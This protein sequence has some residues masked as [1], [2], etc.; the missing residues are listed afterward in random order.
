MTIFV[1]DTSVL[2]SA[3]KKA[4]SLYPGK[5][6]VVPLVVITEL[7][8]KRND[9]ELGLTARSALR[10]IKELRQ[11]GD[12]RTGV[13]IANGSVV[14]VEI[15]HIDNTNLPD[16]V[17]RD[18]S[19]DAKILAVAASLKAVLVTQDIP[20]MIKADVV[21]VQSEP[22]PA[23]APSFEGGD[24]PVVVLSDHDI[25]E[26]HEHGSV[27][28]EADFPV[29]TG[30][31]IGTYAGDGAGIGIIDKQWNVRRV[32][33]PKIM[34]IEGRN[35]QQRFA[36]DHLLN[37]NIGIVSLGGK[38]GSGKSL[39]ALAA[40]VSQVSAGKYKKVVVFKPA[41]EVLGGNLGY[42]PGSLEEKFAG[43][44]ASVYD[45]AE[46]FS[47][48]RDFQSLIKNNQ[49]EILPVSH[50]RGRTLNNSFIIFDEAQNAEFSTLLTVLTRVGRSSKIVL[51]HDLAQRD[52][53]H[54]GKHQGVYEVVSRFTG[55][56]LFA[57]VEMVKSERSEIAEMA[58]TILGDYM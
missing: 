14:R 53:L 12:I 17:R 27:K 1:L 39:L 25:T 10:F 34:G 49:L 52:N 44:T 35:I 6:V 13:R 45:A 46:A 47:G 5:E 42:L 22:I 7:E 55:N 30:V 8:K 20:L 33:S 2:L 40:G 28:T 51:A 43:F 32:Q 37:E 19:N 24:I 38:S 9:P 16:S 29:N 26:F 11:Q 3:G 58:A 23:L 18:N 54:V 48:A 56:K 21:G 57:H 36:V 41:Y 50:I 4:F 31:L 15:N